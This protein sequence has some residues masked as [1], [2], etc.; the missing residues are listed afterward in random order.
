VQRNGFTPKGD[1]FP[2]VIKITFPDQRKRGIFENGQFPAFIGFGGFVRG[3]NLLADAASKLTR[4]LVFFTKGWVIGF[5]NAVRV[6]L[7]RVEYER[8]EPVQGLDVVFDYVRS[9]GG[10]LDF[11]FGGSDDF[12]CSGSF[13]PMQ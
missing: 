11:Y 10:A 8:R 13:M 4:K 5:G 2:G 12:H 1:A 7:F 6:H 9:F 3:C